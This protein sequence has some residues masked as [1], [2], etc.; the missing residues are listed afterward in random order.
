MKL[1]KL[2][3]T[4]LKVSNLCLGTMTFGNAPPLVGRAT[5]EQGTAGFFKSIKGLKHEFVATWD[6]EGATVLEFRATYF[7]HDGKTVTIPAVT[8]FRHDGTRI[9]DG[10]VFYDPTPIYA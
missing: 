1:R 3:R 6:E 5:I 10:R 8:I 7:R 2:G 4:G 9:R